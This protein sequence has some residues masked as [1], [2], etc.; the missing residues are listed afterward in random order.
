MLNKKEI[1][2]T[3][4]VAVVLAFCASL[5]TD[6][7]TFFYVLAS[8]LIILTVNTTAKKVAAYYCDSEI[9][10][11]LWEIS[12]FG[13][14]ANWRFKK[15]APAGLIIPLVIS[16]LSVGYVKWLA[17]LV[18]D[19]TPKPYRAAKRH[20]LY[21]FSEMTESHIGLIAA[22]GILANLFFAVVGYLIGTPEPMNFVSLSVFYALFNMLPIS[23]LDGNKIFFGSIEL[24][25]F[26][27]SLVLIAVALVFLVV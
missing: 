11:K 10:I 27:A 12:R 1:T 18:F 3:A 25:G 15:P 7:L 17:A 8:I 19:V 26:L 9:E 14:K 5:F 21:R 13:F 23:D 4:V 22:S 16:M 20:G 2:I 24:W 6:T